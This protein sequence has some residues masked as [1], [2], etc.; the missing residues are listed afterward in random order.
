MTARKY[1]IKRF[2]SPHCEVCEHY[3]SMHIRDVGCMA[4]FYL[5]HLALEGKIP[6]EKA[7]SICHKCFMESLPV[8]VIEQAKQV[9]PMEWQQEMPCAHCGELWMAH[10][11]ALCPNMCTVFEP[12]LSIGDAAFISG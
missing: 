3:K 10:T 2:V 12:M 5:V 6:T 9:S 11:G 8:K 7:Q 1:T 4:C